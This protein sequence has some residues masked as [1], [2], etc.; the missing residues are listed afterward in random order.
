M[1]CFFSFFF[2]CL[3]VQVSAQNEEA[4]E[5]RLYDLPDVRF[6]KISKPQDKHL[7]YLLSI[8]QPLD[9]GD[10][11]KGF[12]YQS[13]VLT[14]KGFDKPVVME[15]EGYEMRYSG[16]E[17]EKMLDANNIN[18]EHRYFGSSRPDSLQ[19]QYLTFEQVTADLHHVNR[20]FRAVYNG[21]WISTGISRGGQ[22]AIYYRYFY[23]DDV[24]LT[25]PYVAPLPN[26]LEDKRIYHFL[27]TVGSADCRN[28]LFEVQRF[29]LLHAD[30]A[31]NK[32]R[33]YAKG[34]GLTFAYLGGLEK[35]FEYWIL[36]YP[37]SFWQIG[38]TP[39]DRIP[40]NRSVDD[41]LEHL[42]TGVGGIE[43]LTDK[44]IDEWVPNGYMAKT[45]MGF[46]GYDLGRYRK[47]LRHLRGE[48]PSAAFVP[49]S[50]PVKPF[51]SSFTQAVS[52]WLDAKGNNLLYVYG[53][54]D[55]W[56]ACRVIVSP[57]V[58][59]KS[60]LITGANHYKARVRNMPPEMQKDF[61]AAVARMTGLKADPDALR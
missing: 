32:L 3:F 60:Y 7:K 18:V 41:Y 31:V 24:D 27:D 36:E 57:N 43:F 4:L 56:S 48:N 38:H 14:H 45:Q 33:W 58:N 39:C 52:R 34:K 20:L 46:Y 53:S 13:A 17:M 19:W 49:P 16:N 10:P 42:I 55:T 9:H 44:S 22:T 29:L 30:E 11:G 2:L 12:F 50:V 23:P 51:D 40:T 21:K 15:T 59:A 47:Y 8:K 26:S 35:A 28:K 37:F 25:V 1:K 6:Q 5:K 54:T 61:A